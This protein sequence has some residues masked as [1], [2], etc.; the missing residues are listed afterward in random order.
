MNYERGKRHLEVA[1]EGLGLRRIMPDDELGLA[2]EPRFDEEEVCEV[3]V[4]EASDSSD[5]PE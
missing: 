1:C 5:M 2:D 4:C 3:D